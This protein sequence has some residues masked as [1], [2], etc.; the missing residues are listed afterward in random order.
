[1]E[2]YHTIESIF[3]LLGDSGFQF[4]ELNGIHRGSLKL[5][6][7]LFADPLLQK[8]YEELELIDRLVVAENMLKPSNYYFAARKI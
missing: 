4:I 6:E 5:P 7:P 1:M 2:T 8:R 3:S